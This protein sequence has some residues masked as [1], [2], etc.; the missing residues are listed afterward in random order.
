M[1]VIQADWRM[2]P[3]AWRSHHPW[4]DLS[5]AEGPEGHEIERQLGNLW[6]H[7]HAAESI[8]SSVDPKTFDEEITYRSVPP[9]RSYVVR[10]VCVEVR[11]GEPRPFAVDDLTE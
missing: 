8:H 6:R 2:P 11:K 10:V 1:S 3:D 5:P 9:K 4:S 7:R